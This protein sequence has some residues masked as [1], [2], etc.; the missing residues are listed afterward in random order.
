[1][2]NI[3][4]NGTFTMYIGEGKFSTSRRYPEP[5]SFMCE[6]DFMERLAAAKRLSE[7]AEQAVSDMEGVLLKHLGAEKV[8]H[9]DDERND[10][11]RVVE[12]G[13]PFVYKPETIEGVRF[14]VRPN[15]ATITIETEDGKRVGTDGQF[16]FGQIKE[17]FKICFPNA[18]VG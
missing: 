12:R 9:V 11:M 5:D 18:L 1:M 2:K 10:V 3:D 15:D 4:I 8:E 7:R 13:N 17:F 6:A 16:T 14:V